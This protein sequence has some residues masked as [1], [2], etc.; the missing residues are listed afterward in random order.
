MDLHVVK[1]NPSGNTTLFVTDPIPK[2]K[3]AAVARVLMDTTCFAAEQVGFLAGET[4]RPA[5]IFVSMMGGEFCGNAVRCAAALQYFKTRKDGE[6][7]EYDVCCSGLSHNVRTRA[8][9]IARTVFDITAEMPHPLSAETVRAGGETFCRVALPGIV[10]FCHV[11]ETMPSVSEKEKMTRAVLEAFPTEA[12]GATGILFYDG[13][14]LDPFVYVKETDTL[15]NESSCGSGTAA[16]AAHL[17]LS[18][19]Q[20]IHIEAH[21][22]GGLIYADAEAEAGKLIALSIGGPV[23]LTAEGIAYIE[24]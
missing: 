18:A 4:P 13:F 9:Q 8:R 16:L 6:T 17:A 12:G 23:I 7:A 22:A 11:T 24:D 2:E 19:N 10:H 15:V 14:T 5:D 1:L 21:Q 3:R 20:K